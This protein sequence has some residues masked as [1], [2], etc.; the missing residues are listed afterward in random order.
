MKIIRTKS[1]L[2]DPF[3]TSLVHSRPHAVMDGKLS[4][5]VQ[6]ANGLCS[7][8]SC[9]KWAVETLIC[10]LP[11]DLFPV[12]ARRCSMGDF[13]ISHPFL[14]YLLHFQIARWKLMIMNERSLL[15]NLLVC[16]LYHMN[17]SAFRMAKPFSVLRC[18]SPLTA[19]SKEYRLFDVT[20]TVLGLRRIRPYVTCEVR[21]AS[22]DLWLY[23][24]ERNK[25]MIVRLIDIS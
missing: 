5:E 20:S 19:L 23:G 2:V 7:S 18:W 4:V 9:S 1:R 8:D 6:H 14:C 13:G 15:A 25:I 22:Q 16:L 10:L 12:H 24:L 11:V 21:W 17:T 3:G